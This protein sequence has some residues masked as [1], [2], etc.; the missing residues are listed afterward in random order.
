MTFQKVVRIHSPQYEWTNVR[1]NR[2]CHLTC[3]EE[4]HCD[5]QCEG[6]HVWAQCTAV[7]RELLQSAQQVSPCR[8]GTRLTA[9]RPHRISSPHPLL[10]PLHHCAVI[11]TSDIHFQV[12]LAPSVTLTL[13]KYF[14]FYIDLS[15]LTGRRSKWLQYL[16][17]KIV[18][19]RKDK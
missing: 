17:N 6:S 19:M 10:C 3:D 2:Q 15:T 5:L 8:A 12:I 1:M 4:R 13:R 7:S 14:I 18:R 16:Q 11:R 9:A